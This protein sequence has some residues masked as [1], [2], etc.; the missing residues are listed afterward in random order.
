MKL[1]V[2]G[3]TGFIGSHLVHRLV[4]DGH[5]VV[6]LVRDRAKAKD[7]PP[8]VELLDGD[9]TL[10]E[11]VKLELPACDAVIHLAGVVAADKIEDY[12]RIN[13]VAVKHLVAC[14]ERQKWK[15]KRF[16]FASSLAAA[17]P[18]ETP[19]TE[20]DTCAPIEA[21]GKSKLDAERFLQYAPFP[22][23]LFRPSVVFGHGDPATITLFKMAKRGLG[24]RVAG[25]NP[26][27]SFIDVD[28]LVD[29]I[30]RMLA[31]TSRENRTYFVSHPSSTDQRAMWRAIGA[32]VEKRVMIVPVPRQLLYGLMR[33]GVSSQLDEKQ[34]KQITAPGFVC[35][36][37][38]LQ[39]DTG[40]K[41]QY[42]LSSSLAKAAAGFRRA[43]W[44]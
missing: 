27:L 42:D 26:S 40:W 32:A 7:L 30:V 16:L 1:L 5:S 36:S 4:R 23:T 37:T 11:N 31:D 8:D 12:D 6:A 20:R 2:T 21:Y 33:I 22:V 19:M 35:S 43:Q 38:A 29:G 18:S 41:P 13:F 24:F 9:L 15:P 25:M 14:I 28:D 10:F 44:L 39:Q 17:G 3:A 34:Y